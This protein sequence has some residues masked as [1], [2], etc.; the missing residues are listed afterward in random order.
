VPAPTLLAPQEQEAQ[1]L[2]GQVTFR[3]AYPKP[4]EADQAFQVLIWKEGQSHDG[5][6]QIWTG[7]EQTID[8]D[9]VLPQRGGTGEYFWTVVVRQ[10]NTDKLLSPEPGPW[11][12][13]YVGSEAPPNKCA[14][15]CEQCTSWDVWDE[16]PCAECGCTEPEEADSGF[17][18][19]M[20]AGSPRYLVVARSAPRPD[21]R[22]VQPGDSLQGQGRNLVERLNL[23]I[24]GRILTGS[25]WTDGEP[26]LPPLLLRW[27]EV[28]FPGNGA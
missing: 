6:A 25:T 13:V 23:A 26:H 3:W 19:F 7:T 24:T 16:L 9:V 28:L 12:L 1:S 4:L 27:L 17:K 21:S 11:R 22:D 14:G 18:P 20:A 10:K 15:V 8:L 2:R 5:A